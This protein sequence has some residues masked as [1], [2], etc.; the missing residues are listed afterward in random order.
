LERFT[1]PKK[2]PASQPAIPK[3]TPRIGFRKDANARCW[4]LESRI[5][6][7]G[8]AQRILLVLYDNALERLIDESKQSITGDPP[9]RL[10]ER[11]GRGGSQD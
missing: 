6:T 3:N 7:T 9:R 11:A 8:L 5:S 4:E 2:H 10:L 1:G